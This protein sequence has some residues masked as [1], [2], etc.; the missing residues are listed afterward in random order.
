M[1]LG[2]SLILYLTAF[3]VGA[4]RAKKIEV[5]IPKIITGG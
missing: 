1:E 4:P 3:G 5:F 2:G